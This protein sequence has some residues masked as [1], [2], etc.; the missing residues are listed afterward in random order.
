MREMTRICLQSMESA[1]I[2]PELAVT[3]RPLKEMLQQYRPYRRQLHCES[4]GLVTTV[5][6]NA[7]EY[8]EA[9]SVSKEKH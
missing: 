8:V 7:C 3:L 9:A 5:T 1:T 2:N 6:C 4:D